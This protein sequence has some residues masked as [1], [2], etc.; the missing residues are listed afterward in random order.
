MFAHY[1]KN[2]QDI[3]DVIAAL[4]DTYGHF[5]DELLSYELRGLEGIATIDRIMKSLRKQAPVLFR[6]IKIH[7]YEDYLSSSG[8][9]SS[10]HR[11]VIRLP[12]SDVVRLLGD[13]GSI[14]FR[15][16]GTEPKLKVYLSFHH[17]EAA[18]AQR[19]VSSS[20]AIIDRFVKGFT[21][22]E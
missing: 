2:N 17:H 4:Y 6:D 8:V 3:A 10:G 1:H 9:D 13:H 11:Y 16:S 15:P 18:E 19:L 7:T 22:N 21:E 20:K 5:V 12:K 14:V